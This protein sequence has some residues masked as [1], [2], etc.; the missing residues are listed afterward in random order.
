M[1]NLI[2]LEDEYYTE[3]YQDTIRVYGEFYW[4]NFGEDSRGTKWY[5]RQV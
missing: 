2:S 4:S 3:T 5:I 1:L